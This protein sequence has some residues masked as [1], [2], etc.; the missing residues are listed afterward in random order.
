MRF[1]E[2][3][4]HDK[5]KRRLI[6]DFKGGRLPHS[7]MFLSEPGIGELPL[8][9]AMSQYMNCENP[10]ETD[11]CGECASCTKVSKMIHPDVHYSFPTISKPG[12]KVVTSN[13]Y[14]ENFRQAVLGEP[15]LNYYDWVGSISQD[16]K[17]GNITREECRNISGKLGLKPFESK[18]KILIMWLP[19]YLGNSGNALL[20]LVEEPPENTFFFFVANDYDRILNTILSR[21]RLIKLIQPNLKE[22]SGFLQKNRHVSEEIAENA[23]FISVG[24][25]NRAIRSLDVAGTDLTDRFREWMLH[26]YKGEVIKLMQWTTDLGGENRDTIKQ[27]LAHG[28][29]VLRECASTRFIPSY[30]IKLPTKDED[31]VTKFAQI[32]DEWKVEELTKWISE[33]I[34]HVDRNANAK[35]VLFDLSL[36]IKQELRGERVA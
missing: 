26:C 32:I 23:A 4:G 13:D 16:Q 8:A 22:L 7:I 14:V 33:A 28:L 27:F 6:S 3:V 1:E 29:L 36:R 15:Y 30:R 34:Y 20:K 10:T 5:L 9:L 18:Y 11:S 21:S 17:Q 25:V 31:F 2:V 19:E 12:G 35:I 24:N